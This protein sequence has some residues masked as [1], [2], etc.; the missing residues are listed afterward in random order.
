MKGGQDLRNGG[1][2]DGGLED[3]RPGGW[4][5][6]RTAILEDIRIGE[7]EAWRT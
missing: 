2:E 4:D 6:W 7:L 1:I 5:D 3:W